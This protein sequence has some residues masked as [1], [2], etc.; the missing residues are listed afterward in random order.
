M[1]GHGIQDSCGEGPNGGASARMCYAQELGC[2]RPSRVDEDVVEVGVVMASVGEMS[3][4]SSW[5][6]GVLELG[7]EERDQHGEKREVDDAVG[8]ITLEVVCGRAGR[9]R[10][11]I[12]INREFLNDV[13]VSMI[14]EFSG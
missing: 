12:N 9:A 6:K 2:Q 11:A 10:V 4:N 3:S 13:Q 7:I 8:P 14:A 1:S 5:M